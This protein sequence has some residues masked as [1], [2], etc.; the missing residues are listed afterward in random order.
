MQLHRY[1]LWCT[2]SIQTD[3]S[4]VWM[5]ATLSFIWMRSPSAQRGCQYRGVQQKTNKQKRQKSWTRLSFCCNVIT[6]NLARCCVCQAH[7]PGVLFCNMNT[8]FLLFTSQLSTPK[9]KIVYAVTTFQSSIGS[10]YYKLLCSFLES[11]KPSNSQLCYS[12]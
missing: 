8:V 9:N 12:N 3:F 6:H 11:D 4:C 10:Y 1:F 5:K 2:V 7:I